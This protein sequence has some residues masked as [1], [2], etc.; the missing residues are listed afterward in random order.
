LIVRRAHP[1][2]GDAD[3]DDGANA[4]RA[5]ARGRSPILII[6]E[7]GGVGHAIGGV[8][9][10]ERAEKRKVAVVVCLGLAVE[11]IAFGFWCARERIAPQ[12]EAVAPVGRSEVDREHFYAP[13]I[14]R[15][16]IRP[17][18]DAGLADDEP[19]LGVVVGGKSRA[20]R[21]E[22]MRDRYRHIVNDV[23]GDHP[24]SVAYCDINDYATVFAGEPGGATLPIS[25][26][27]RSDGDMVLCVGGAEY[28]QKTLGPAERGAAVP[29]FPYPTV[30]VSRATWKEW[31]A[32]HPET[33]VY[34]GFGDAGRGPVE[35]VKPG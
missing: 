20:Y 23:I 14:D 27:G 4:A 32:Q 5:S 30:P 18:G 13:G 31:R 28:A 24:V 19:V 2:D 22:A 29:M 11:V 16:P 34:E 9:D 33:D 10:G 15:P 6:R 3:S 35:R 1:W 25:Q 17:V 8:S 21:V 7:A 12:G 26:G